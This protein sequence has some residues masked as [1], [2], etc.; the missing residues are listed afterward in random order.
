[1]P[2]T[3]APTKTGLAFE[4]YLEFEKTSPVKH[5]LVDGQLF[6]MAGTSERHN[7]IAG[8]TYALLLAAED[9]TCRTYFADIALRTPSNDGYYPDVFV[10]C[11]KDDDNE[12]VKHKPC[13]IVEVLSD[14]TEAIDRG[15][16]LGNYTTIPTLQ[17]YVLLSQHE[18][19]AEV[20]SRAGKGWHYEVIQAEDVVKLPCIKLELPL[21]NFYV[22]V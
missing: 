3:Q 17:A 20:Y 7:R 14:S 15:E 16:K 4:D 18:V 10:V 1:V 9:G 19:K 5:E 2:R 22:G 8:R 13:L 6:V 12:Y 11:E 21:Q